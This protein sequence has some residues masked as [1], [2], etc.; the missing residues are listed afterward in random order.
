MTFT[1]AAQNKPALRIPWWLPVLAIAALWRIVVL[2][3]GAVSFHSDE[4]IV[5]LMAR[6][7]NQ[8]QPIP[9]FFYGQPYMGSLDPWLVSIAFRLFGESVLSI[10]LVQSALYLA[11]VGTTM[12]LAL[13]LSASVQVAAIA[14][15]LIAIPPTVLT[16]YTTVSLGGY[17]ETLVI[18]NL[19]LLVGYEIRQRQK[20]SWRYWLALG[21][22]TG[23][24]WWT[25]SL[26]VV[27]AIPVAILLLPGNWRRGRMI[28]LA[29][30]AFIVGSL[31]WWL[32]KLEPRLGISAFF[33]RW[34][35][36]R[37][38]SI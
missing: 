36:R 11:L 9:V 28:M 20:A 7:I 37:G 4:A 38:R 13:R 34:L 27:Y 21:F 2:A 33:V 18:G 25:N 31:P 16:L 32:Y 15:L 8:G 12:L 22:V 30:V 6:H 19:L 17:G 14:G 26:I 29:L 35:W 24:G 1:H 3:S 23:L 10:R 5:G